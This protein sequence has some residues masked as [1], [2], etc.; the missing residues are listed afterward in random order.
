MPQTSAGLINTLEIPLKLLLLVWKERKIIAACA[1]QIVEA[2]ITGSVLSVGVALK[3]REHLNSAM[4]EDLALSQDAELAKKE[5]VLYAIQRAQ[6]DIKA[7]A[8]RAIRT[9]A[10]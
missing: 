3:L 10:A 6:V 9:A 8:I 5:S 7:K 4:A 2:I 1:I